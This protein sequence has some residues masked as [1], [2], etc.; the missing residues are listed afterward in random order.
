MGES[1]TA[2][3]RRAVL[4]L[5]GG[6]PYYDSADATEPS[7]HLIGEPVVEMTAKKDGELNLQ[8]I[9]PDGRRKFIS[10]DVKALQIPLWTVASRGVRVYTQPD[11]NAPAIATLEHGAL[12]E[13]SGLKIELNGLAWI[14]VDLRDGRS[15]YVDAKLKVVSHGAQVRIEGGADNQGAQW[16]LKDGKLV[17]LNK[18]QKTP[19]DAAVR[20]MAIG[21]AWCGVGLVV[22]IAT[23]SAATSGG[24]YY[25]IM[26]GPV[27]FGGIRFLRGAFGYMK[28]M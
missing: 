11:A 20:N 28:S 13:Q 25:V 5:G 24:G 26:W 9:L 27:L 23:M 3:W 12:I 7:G 22:T 10:A 19:R 8:A 2:R 4:R 15:G 1:E 14:P 21:G 6:V 17:P 16:L 18:R